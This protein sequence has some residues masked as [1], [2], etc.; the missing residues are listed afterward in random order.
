MAEKV[1]AN[2]LRI[3]NLIHPE[4]PMRIVSIYTDSVNA[5]FD[6]NEGDV[7]EYAAKYIEPIP[8]TEECLLKFGFKI[9][10]SANSFFLSIPEL[11]AEIHFEKF[12]GALV[13]VIYCGTGSF[14]PNDIKYAHTLQNL[15]FSLTGEEL[16]PKQ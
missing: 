12:R 4:F 3:G 1:K 7:F 10:P 11:K 14:I 9:S 16:K 6:G 8:I 13:C 15:Y 5:D 2:E